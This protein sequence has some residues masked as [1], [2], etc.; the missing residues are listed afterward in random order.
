MDK[1]FC[2]QIDRDSMVEQYVTG[3]LRGELLVQFEQHL[4]ECEEHARA[5][6]LEKALKRGVAEFARGEIKTRL[7]SRLKKRED[8][9][10][11]MLRYAAI[12]FVAVIT[13]LLLYYS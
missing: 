11:M 4:K 3:K 5:V 1:K 7:R 8:T 9:R 6:L 13:P 2:R 12:L 10:F